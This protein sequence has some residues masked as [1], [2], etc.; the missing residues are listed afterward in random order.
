[1]RFYL[2]PVLLAVSSTAFS[3]D[4]CTSLS[5]NQKRLA[6]YDMK[7]KPVETTEK[8]GK[9]VVINEVS[10]IDDTKS[11]Y[12]EVSSNEKIIKRS[13][14]S[15]TATLTIRCRERKTA[16]IITLAGEFLADVG[17]YGSV[18]YRIDNLKAKTQSFDASTNNA[19]LGL[20]SGNESIPVIKSLFDH[21]VLVVRATPYN[22]S[23]ETLTFPISELK[24]VI[25]PLR[26]ACGW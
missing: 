18:T 17:G 10:K 11:V 19:S 12:L 24:S 20:W 15:D 6:C 5:D 23:P 1:M 22:Q 4:E 8:K 13:G 16:L 2:L 9:W 21:E 3:A 25:D 26:K 14:G 7:Y